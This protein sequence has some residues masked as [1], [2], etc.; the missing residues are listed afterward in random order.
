MFFLQAPLPE[1]PAERNHPDFRSH[2]GTAVSQTLSCWGGSTNADP[3]VPSS[4]AWQ[5]HL[6]PEIRRLELQKPLRE[7]AVSLYKP[8]FIIHYLHIGSKAAVQ[9]FPSG[10]GMQLLPSQGTA[11]LPAWLG[12]NFL[13]RKPQSWRKSEVALH[14]TALLGRPPFLGLVEAQCCAGLLSLAVPV[15]FNPPQ[16]QHLSSP[17]CGLQLTLSICLHSWGVLL[18][19]C[20][21]LVNSR[22][23]L[24]SFSL[25]FHSALGSSI[26]INNFA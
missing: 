22:L 3:T 8:L 26:N 19:L 20:C 16:S 7:K 9:H 5:Q 1:Q 4:R 23:M 10:A 24:C 2:A 21:C 12:D 18:W 13:L 25:L 15:V 14:C 6:Y 11:S 17:G